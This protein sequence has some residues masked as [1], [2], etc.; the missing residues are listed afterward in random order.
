[1]CEESDLETIPGPI[2]RGESLG[3]IRKFIYEC[4]RGKQFFL[5]EKSIVWNFA[6]KSGIYIT[7]EIIRRSIL[8]GQTSSCNLELANTREMCDDVEE[9]QIWL[10]VAL[11]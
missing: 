9:A 8:P 5:C 7:T 3:E 10:D 4:H 6:Q 1:M 2:D 11:V